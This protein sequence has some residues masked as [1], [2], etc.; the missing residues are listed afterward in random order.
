MADKLPIEYPLPLNETLSNG[1][2]FVRLQT[3]DAL[4]QF[5]DRHKNE[6]NYQF[7]AT[8]VAMTTGH[9]FLDDC[10]W[11]FGPTKEAVINTLFRWEQ[12]KI[13]A[14]FHDLR[15]NAP[16]E[17]EFIR[18]D[19]ESFRASQVEESKW[20]D[21]DEAE[22]LDFVSGYV[23]DWDLTNLPGGN[24]IADL[25]QPGKP[26]QDVNASPDWVI[27]NFQVQLFDDMAICGG[28]WD[29]ETFIASGVEDYIKDWEEERASGGDYY[30]QE[31]ENA[32]SVLQ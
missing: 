8:G 13:E 12:L 11:V 28:G 5:W 32:N 16:K 9:W 21:E 14:I 19:A 27:Q 3:L 30:G 7:A 4:R 23:G 6:A 24:S 18:K 26:I 15:K 1:T 17:L 29:V 25:L 22:Y 2:T 10:D 31:H 20:S